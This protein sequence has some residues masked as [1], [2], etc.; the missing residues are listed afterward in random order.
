MPRFAHASIRPDT[1]LVKGRKYRVKRDDNAVIAANVRAML[2]SG[3]NIPVL[4]FHPEEGT[5]FGGPT[6]KSK[7]ALDTTG[8]V[9][10]AKLDQRGRLKLFFEVN[11]P[12]HAE[13]IR[14]K[15]IRFTSPELTTSFKDETGR[16]W[17]PCVRHL[18]L[19]AF[20]RVS[21]TEDI[22]EVVEQDAMPFSSIESTIGFSLM[23]D[24]ESETEITEE[25]EAKKKA[26]TSEAAE[27]VD[28]KHVAELLEKLGI[29]PPRACFN[30]SPADWVKEL[31]S[32]MQEKATKDFLAKTPDR[33]GERDKPLGVKEESY[34]TAQFAQFS[35]LADHPDEN[36]KALYAQFSQEM[37]NV[38]NERREAARKEL[39]AK[40]LSN[41]HWIGQK[42]REMLEGR[43]ATVQFSATA[44]ATI[45]EPTFTVAEVLE[46]LEAQTPPESRIG[47]PNVQEPDPAMLEKKVIDP[48][49]PKKVTREEARKIAEEE[50]RSQYRPPVPA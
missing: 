19:T 6:M 18:A 39:S 36:V 29:T 32:S 8:W 35:A 26:V 25:P 40:L 9:T 4:P 20:P 38:A 41:S 2:N 23:T 12:E 34:M 37:E 31:V 22:E 1:Y 42:A 24:E 33:S 14:N 5:E 46:V 44:D 47:T 45:E 50:R 11:S 43:I 15:Q 49:A 13:G 7:D 48:N 28:E 3:I 30:D 27:P 10:D 17:G 16:E 21:G